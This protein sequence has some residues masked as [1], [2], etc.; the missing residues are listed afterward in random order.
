V[1]TTENQESLTFTAPKGKAT[2]ELRDITFSTDIIGRNLHF[3][4]NFS[5]SGHDNILYIALKAGGHLLLEQ[6]SHLFRLGLSFNS[7][8]MG[9][10]QVNLRLPVSHQF[11]RRVII[12]I[13]VTIGQ[14]A[15]LTASAR[16]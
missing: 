10:S 16:L 3:I 4:W 9:Q 14:W 1:L 6:L 15:L 5:F 2:E 8:T 13:L 7:L 11:L 12:G